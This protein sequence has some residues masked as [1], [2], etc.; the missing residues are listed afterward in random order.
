MKGGEKMNKNRFLQGRGKLVI[1]VLL[2]LLL[3]GSTLAGA[4]PRI[5]IRF[6]L[7]PDVYISIPRSP[8]ITLSIDK[9]ERANYYR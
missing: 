3:G 7:L 2:A 6:Q 8:Q 1:L 9:G 5:S 4:Q